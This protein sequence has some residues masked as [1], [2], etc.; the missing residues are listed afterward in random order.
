MRQTFVE[1]DN[2]DDVYKEC[3]W[4]EV[5]IKV[6][7]GFMAFESAWDWQVWENQK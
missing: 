3:P 4:V 1:C 7:G 5:V 2:L 6:V